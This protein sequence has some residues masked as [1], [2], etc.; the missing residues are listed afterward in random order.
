[1][2]EVPVRVDQVRDGI[3]AEI[4]ESFGHLRA[5]YADAGVDQ[6]LAVGARQH[7]DVSTGAF[8][9][10]D[11]VSQLVRDDGRGTAALSLIR[12][13][14]PRASAN[15]SRG[16][17]Q[18]FAARAAPPM[19]QRQKPRRDIKCCFES[20]M[21]SSLL[22]QPGDDGRW[23]LERC[24]ISKLTVLLSITRCVGSAR[25]IS[26][27]CGPGVSPWIISGSPLA[28][29]QCQVASSRVTWIWPIRGV[30]LSAA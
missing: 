28:S 17:S 4:G 13:T 25:S 1:M 20:S 18:P 3:G 7:G 2:V 15:A 8:E 6:H 12:L 26:T 23:A 30:T 21:V 11:I 5:R 9:H 27:R 14:M 29:T 10:A 22:R 19:Q 16:V 24:G